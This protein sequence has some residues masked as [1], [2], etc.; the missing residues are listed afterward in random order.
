MAL[1]PPSNPSNVTNY[2]TDD[3][4]TN[5]Y[6]LEHH[7]EKLLETVVGVYEQ[8]GVPLPGRKYWMVGAPPEDCAQ[9][10]VS[11]LQIYLGTPGDQAADIQRCDSP[12][13]AVVNVHITRDY[14]IGELGK[15]VSTERI[16]AASS[17]AAV[18][19]WVLFKAMREFDKDEWGV[20][21]LGAIATVT[22]RPPAGG[23]QT[24]VLNLSTAVM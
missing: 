18:D 7:L 22:A 21:G 24:T 16:T 5:I 1:T 17:W 4:N 9:V 19:S 3:G 20:P 15:T 6:D 13:T 8:A 14:P 2:V 11:L 10:V 12:T 23:V